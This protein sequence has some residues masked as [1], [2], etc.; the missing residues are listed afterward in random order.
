MMLSYLLLKKWKRGMILFL[1]NPPSVLHSA[2]PSLRVLSCLSFSSVRVLLYMW[3]VL[4]SSQHISVYFYPMVDVLVFVVV[5]F[6]LLYIYMRLKII[7]QRVFVNFQTDI[8]LSWSPCICTGISS[9]RAEP[10]MWKSWNFHFLLL[11]QSSYPSCSPEFKGTPSLRTK[12]QMERWAVSFCWSPWFIA[13][14]VSERCCKGFTWMWKD[15]HWAQED[16]T[17]RS[18][19]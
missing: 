7:N 6:F 19:A 9:L 10:D 16:H 11:H 5:L 15:C 14:F 2:F 3:C 1:Q 17:A 18:A 12:R 13:Y 4:I 8:V